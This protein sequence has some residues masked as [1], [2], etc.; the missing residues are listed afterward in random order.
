MWRT[1]L[2]ALY[3]CLVLLS[4]GILSGRNDDLH[5]RDEEAKVQW[6][7]RLAQAPT[8]SVRQ[9]LGWIQ[10]F[11]EFITLCCFFIDSFPHEVLL[12]GWWCRVGLNICKS[13]NGINHRNGLKE[14]NHRVI[15]IDGEK[16]F[17]KLHHAFMLKVLESRT[18]ENISQHNKNYIWETHSQQSS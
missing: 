11:V 15:S 8:A 6:N 7:Q 10:P 12:W 4:L 18:R 9:D 16:A 3:N 2:Y 14:K 13:V 1:V 5:S 17:D